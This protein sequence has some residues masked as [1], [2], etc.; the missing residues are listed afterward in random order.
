MTET[1]LDEESVT[2][3][4]I[5]RILA[6][7]RERCAQIAEKAGKDYGEPAIGGAIA[8]KIRASPIGY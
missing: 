4:T 1:K 7:E 2:A 8:K 5:R 6:E 3:F